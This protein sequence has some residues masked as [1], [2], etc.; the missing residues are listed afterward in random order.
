MVTRALKLSLLT[1]R[2]GWLLATAGVALL[3]LL[4]HVLPPL[5][6]QMFIVRG[7]SMVPAVPLGSLAITA[8][9]D[10]SHIQAGDVITFHGTNGTIVTHRVLSIVD[11]QN[12]FQT[13]GDAS[14]ATDPTPVAHDALIG[15][16]EHVVPVL[17]VAMAAFSTSLGI[18]AAFGLIGGLMLAS[19]FVE[20]LLAVVRRSSQRAPVGE[21]AH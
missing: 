5:D 2:V 13:K 10:P 3:A 17:G 14:A 16:V 6:R 20:E 19:F 9:V 18:I 21:P 1:M 15:R 11:G 8:K 12:A 4:P 7:S